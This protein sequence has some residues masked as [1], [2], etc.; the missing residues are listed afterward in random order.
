MKVVNWLRAKVLNS[1]EAAL[2]LA[3]EDNKYIG[4][5]TKLV[6]AKQSN[7]KGELNRAMGHKDLPKELKDIYFKGHNGDKLLKKKEKYN[8]ILKE[9]KKIEF[10]PVVTSGKNRGSYLIAP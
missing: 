6:S 3:R 10:K 5:A 1:S 7:L 9:L 8:N 4:F 2:K